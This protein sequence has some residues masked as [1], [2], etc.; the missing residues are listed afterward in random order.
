VILIGGIATISGSIMGAAFVVLMPRLVSELAGSVPFISTAPG[1]GFLTV[2]H[3]QTML[4]GAL[5]VLFLVLEPRGLYGLW[6]RVRNYWKA[7]PFS[8]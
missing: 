5:I 4:F 1:S 8:Y 6:V 2:F 7:W 3:V